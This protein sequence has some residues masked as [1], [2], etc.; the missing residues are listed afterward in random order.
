M[1]V[2]VGKKPQE[3]TREDIPAVSYVPKKSKNVILFSALH[4]DDTIIE[5]TGKKKL[6]E[7]I[8]CYNSTKGGVDKLDELFANY[9]LSRNSRRWTLTLFFLF[10]NSA[11]VNAQ[12]IDKT[13][14]KIDKLNRRIFLKELGMQLISEFRNQRRQNPP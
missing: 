13:N 2:Y 12:V 10:L 5:E 6:P 14:T 11:G 9:S 1:E 8:D 3:P 7:I 4:H